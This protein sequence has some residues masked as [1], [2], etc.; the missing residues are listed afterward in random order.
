MLSTRSSNFELPAAQ[1]K[2]LRRRAKGG[3][4]TGNS[5]SMRGAHE[6]TRDRFIF[7]VNKESSMD[8]VKQNMIN[9]N[10]DVRDIELKSNDESIYNSFH[11]CI[12]VSY[13][14]QVLMPDF[15]TTGNGR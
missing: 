4:G 14:E 1:M 2:K 7:R 15:W 10:V 8:T 13:L 9:K 6:P 5:D 11:I 12:K 3:V